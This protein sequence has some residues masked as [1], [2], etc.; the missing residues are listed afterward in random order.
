M[1]LSPSILGKHAVYQLQLTARAAVVEI[2]SDKLTRADLARVGCFNFMAARM[3]SAVLHKELKVKNLRDVY[4][5]IP[6]SALTLPRLGA[7]SLAVLGAAFEVRKLGDLESYVQKH[8][9]AEQQ[10][11]TWHTMKAHEAAEV[12]RERKEKRA[13]KEKRKGKAH[14]LRVARFEQRQQVAAGGA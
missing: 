1:N 13:R 5:S 10:V 7:V 12:A 3:L 4:E 6:P 11:R 14:E 9:Q 8:L 2:G